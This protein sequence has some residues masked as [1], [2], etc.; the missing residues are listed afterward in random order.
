MA[1]AVPNA[2]EMQFHRFLTA[3]RE[4]GELD[5]APDTFDAV[6]GKLLRLQTRGERPKRA[7]R[8]PPQQTHSGA[9]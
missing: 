4:R 8:A 1:G 7:R 3:L 9:A 2:R 6:L 5:K